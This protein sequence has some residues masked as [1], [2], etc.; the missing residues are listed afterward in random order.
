MSASS[1]RKKRLE[2]ANLPVSET[3]KKKKKKLSQGW[4]FAIC[5]CLVVAFLVGGVLIYRTVKN[6]RTVLTVGD[7]DVTV[8]E[9]NYFYNS[10]A[11][12]LSSYAS[13]V[14]IETGTPLDEQYVTS[15]GAMYLGLFGISSDYLADK[16]LVDDTYDVTWAQLIAN[17]A[18]DNAVNA[19]AIYNEAMK[20][21]YEIDEHLQSE[22]DEQMEVMQGY[23]DANGESLN[24]LIKRVFGSGCSASGYRDYLTV[25]H[26]ASHY[27]S[28]IRYSDAEIQARFD[29]SPETFTVATYYLYSVSATSFEETEED[30]EEAE[31]ADEAEEPDLT[32]EEV[33]ETEPAEET[34]EAEPTD[35][36]VEETE[37]A[38]EEAE[39]AEPTDEESEES[40][41]SEEAKKK[42]E[43]AAKAMEKDFD[44]ENENVSIKTDNTLASA[45]SNVTEE[46]ATWLFDTA[47]EDDVKL[48]KNED[49]T[50]FYVLKLI[51]KSD[52]VTLNGLQLV[53]SADPE[54]L[55][56]GETPAADKVAA[57]NASLEAD[58]SEENFRALIEE[59]GGEPEDLENLTR[60]SVAS[61]SNDVL[62]WFMDGAKQGDYI[63][64]EVNGSTIY[65]YC[66]GLGDTYSTAAVTG[67]LTSEWSEEL[68]N[69]ASAACGYNE[70]VAMTANVGLSFS[71]SN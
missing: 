46:A 7:H 13:Y 4:I 39:E 54:E 43:E 17:A 33:E 10:T 38:E 69:A 8:K 64:A 56:E 6:N 67:T 50:T 32:E 48:F 11:N 68:V 34:E 44:V 65:L 28:S 12:T 63:S 15:N 36:E 18:K 23:A 22:I 52:Y 19:Y 60:S 26:V 51:D 53:I 14:G 41:P 29:E 27:P 25:M 59:Y 42:A 21:G 5:I 71:S 16:E 49:G 30:V 70:E 1:A 45:T 62:K 58:P 55:A 61:V 31:P 40:G 24:G 47:K 3:P 9:F 20:A 57:I 66:T 37:P 2:Q 35:E